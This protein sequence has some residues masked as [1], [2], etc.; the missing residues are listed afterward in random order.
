MRD[1]E[2]ELKRVNSEKDSLIKVI[3]KLFR[4]YDVLSCIIFQQIKKTEEKLE[5]TKKNKDEES[6]KLK[7]KLEEASRKAAK[8]DEKE[9]RKSESFAKEKHYATMLEEKGKIIESLRQENM[10]VRQQKDVLER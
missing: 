9:R 3:I 5:K 7:E 2:K 10:K 1:L 8:K 4:N 6:R